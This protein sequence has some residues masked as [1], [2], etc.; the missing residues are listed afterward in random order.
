LLLNLW[1]SATNLVTSFFI[2]IDTGLAVVGR[3]SSD[4]AALWSHG[5]RIAEVTLAARPGR[6]KP[7]S[8]QRNPSKRM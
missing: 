8:T 4:A 5:E 1:T 6:Q 3:A 7:P 2:Y